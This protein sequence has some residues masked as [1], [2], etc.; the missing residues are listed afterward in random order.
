[1]T[2]VNMNT[3]AIHHCGGVAQ[4][5][6]ACRGFR[7]RDA[8]RHCPD[9]Q[10]SAKLL[11]SASLASAASFGAQQKASNTPIVVRASKLFDPTSGRLLDSPVVLISGNHIE[12]VGSRDLATPA[13]A[14]MIDLGSAT[15]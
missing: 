10:V 3:L 5:A 7:S 12:A 13:N 11:L 14:R 1:H 6:R 9:W 4:R 2:H 15:L 8:R